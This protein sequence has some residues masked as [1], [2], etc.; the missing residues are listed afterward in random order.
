MS[1]GGGRRFVLS[2]S[3]WFCCPEQGMKD[4]EIL[5]R[6]SAFL[7]KANNEKLN[8]TFEEKKLK[9]N[10]K[11]IKYTPLK[12]NKYH[13]LT[14]SHVIAPWKYPKY[15]SQ[16][17]VSYINESHTH[18]T[19]EL[20]NEDGTFITQSELIP[21]SFHHSNRDLAILHLDD[22]NNV[23]KTL[24]SLQLESL[25]LLDNSTTLNSGDDLIFYGHDV[26][27]GEDTEIY[28]NRKPFPCIVNGTFYYKSIHQTFS[29]TNPVLTDGMCGGPVCLL[30][31]NKVS[32]LVEGIV[33][34]NHPDDKL[35]GLAVFVDSKII[36]NFID[37]VEK[38]KIIP[39]LGGDCAIHVGSDQ[40]N[41]KM[42]VAKILT[43][44][45]KY[46]P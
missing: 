30:S 45:I 22:E 39:L 25:E 1:L 33:P 38:G 16:E 42:D 29:K 3:T 7:V 34:T 14:S 12:D 32:G 4:L 28:D 40:D 46:F 35:K 18:Y 26:R 20:R 43:D 19:V 9:E 15:Y 27:G 41:E 44:S 37:D 24:E 11:V 6:A 23:M 17:F 21:R 10:D 5:N 31:S 2:I 36:R 8:N 13:L